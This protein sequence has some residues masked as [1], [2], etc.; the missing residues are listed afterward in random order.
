MVFNRTMF[1]GRNLLALWL[2]LRF[3]VLS[4]IFCYGIYFVR[5]IWIQNV[6]SISLFYSITSTVAYC[7]RR[8]RAITKRHKRNNTESKMWAI[9]LSLNARCLFMLHSVIYVAPADWKHCTKFMYFHNFAKYE[10]LFQISSME[11]F[12][13]PKYVEFTNKLNSYINMRILF[14]KLWTYSSYI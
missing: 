8:K 11:M 13:L 10:V 1:T 6:S 9:R 12:K 2:S 14:K 5:R 4:A 3:F 7:T